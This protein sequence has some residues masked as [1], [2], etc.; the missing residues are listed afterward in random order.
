MSVTNNEQLLELVS[1]AQMAFVNGQYQ[2]AFT[3]AK[4]AI[5]LDNKCADAYQR[6]AR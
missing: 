6:A 1:T 3:L 5:K 4:E 2:E